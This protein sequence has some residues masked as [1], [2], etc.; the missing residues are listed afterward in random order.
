MAA[1]IVAL[2]PHLFC[3]HQ[4]VVI[5]CSSNFVFAPITHGYSAYFEGRASAW[6]LLRR[7][8]MT[9]GFHSIYIPTVWR[10]KCAGGKGFLSTASPRPVGP[11]PPPMALSMGAF[12]PMCPVDLYSN[13]GAGLCDSIFSTLSSYRQKTILIFF[14]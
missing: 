7:M 6:A 1:L 13:R 12:A 11:A 5:N 2:A 4:E 9:Q 8:R 10:K 14:K 3:E